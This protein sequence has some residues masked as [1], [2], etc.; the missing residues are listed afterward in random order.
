MFT[1][2]AHIDPTNC[3]VLSAEAAEIRQHVRKI[4]QKLIQTQAL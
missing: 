2:I 1:T 3:P 4:I